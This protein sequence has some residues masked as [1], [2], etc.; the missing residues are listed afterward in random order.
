M[1]CG[2][3]QFWNLNK[4]QHFQKEFQ[5]F[6]GVNAFWNEIQ[7]FPKGFFSTFKF[8][9]ISNNL[10]VKLIGSG[11]F[12]EYICIKF[13]ENEFHKNNLVSAL[14]MKSSFHK[15]AQKKCAKIILCQLTEPWAGKRFQL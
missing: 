2:P 10:S 14:S 7:G 5:H 1:K 8:I 9:I 15:N 13:L 4:F 3:E 6:E 11:Y 12:W